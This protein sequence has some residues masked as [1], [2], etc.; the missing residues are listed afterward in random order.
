MANYAALVM[1]MYL[2]NKTLHTAQIT[3]QRQNM[4]ESINFGDPL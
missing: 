2:T 1:K 3:S 4:H